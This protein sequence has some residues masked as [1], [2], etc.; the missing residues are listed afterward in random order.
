MASTSEAEATRRAS[1]KATQA[2]KRAERERREQEKSDE[3][4]KQRQEEKKNRRRK[5]PT[6][7]PSV[8]SP[9]KSPL[10]KP[11][12]ST[13]ESHSEN[14]GLAELPDINPEQNSA[15]DGARVRVFPPLPP[16]PSAPSNE[17]DISHL[18]LPDPNQPPTPQDGEWDLADDGDDDWSDSE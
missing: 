8:P 10:P 7:A 16:K 9:P 11:E 6:A 12:T 15:A 13:R 17:P 4:V 5:K 18:E 3:L 2:K 1:E 14:S